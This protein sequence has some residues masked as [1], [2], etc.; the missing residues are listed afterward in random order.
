MGYKKVWVVVSKPSSA[1]Q[2]EFKIMANE[3]GCQSVAEKI[4]YRQPGKEKGHKNEL[5]PR[6]RVT[7]TTNKK[8]RF[9][10]TKDLEEEQNWPTASKCHRKTSE[11]NQKCVETWPMGVRSKATAVEGSWNRSWTQEAKRE[12]GQGQVGTGCVPPSKA[13]FWTKG[14]RKGLPEKRKSIIWQS[15]G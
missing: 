7:D 14:E 4:Q 6:R 11:K 1:T 15:V 8:W 2:Q 13:Q 12:T 5:E 3:H 10:K 9:R